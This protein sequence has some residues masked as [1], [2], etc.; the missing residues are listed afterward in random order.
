MPDPNEKPTDAQTSEQASPAEKPTKTS[1]KPAASTPVERRPRPEDGIVIQALLDLH[2][3]VEERQ[4]A[5]IRGRAPSIGN[6]YLEA[7]RAL[8]DE[9]VMA[10]LGP[11]KG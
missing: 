5:T 2:R 3:T 1:S 8:G 11:A 7:A 6:R 9:L 10:V 4:G